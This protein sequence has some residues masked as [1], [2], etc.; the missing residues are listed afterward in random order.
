MNTNT[1]RS[2]AQQLHTIN[3][4]LKCACPCRHDGFEKLSE[5]DMDYLS[6]N[7]AFQVLYLKA[8][9]LKMKYAES[10]NLEDIKDAEDCLDEL[11]ELAYQEEV[12]VSEPKHWFARA[13]AKYERAKKETGEIRDHLLWKAENII[14]RAHAKWRRNESITWLYDEITRARTLA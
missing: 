4:M 6:P 3:V 10:E 14:S 12:R 7:D 8:K 2:T 13:S 5:F 11:F 1:P 9:Y